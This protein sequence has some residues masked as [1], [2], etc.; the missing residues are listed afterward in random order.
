MDKTHTI[1]LKSLFKDAGVEVKPELRGDP[2]TTVGFAGPSTYQQRSAGISR[3]LQQQRL[4]G[5]KGVIRQARKLLGLNTKKDISRAEIK[6]LQREFAMEK[7]RRYSSNLPAESILA[8]S[9]TNKEIDD[10]FKTIGFANEGLI[11]PGGVY[12]NNAPRSS[13]VTERTY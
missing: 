10:I 9:L 12:E 13:G 6:A 4:Q 1:D 2:G 8:L 3:E 5:V 11:N 7:Q